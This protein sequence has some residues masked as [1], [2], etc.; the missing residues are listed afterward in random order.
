MVIAFPPCTHLAVSGAR[1]FAQKKRSGVQKKAIDF[2]M[3]FTELDVP[4]WAIENPVGIMSKLFRP[5]DQII[6]PFQFGDCAQKTTC[7]WLKNLPRLKPTKLVDKGEMRVWKSRKGKV[8]K[9]ARWVMD[10]LKMDP[11]LRARTR[12]QTFPGVAAAMAEQWGTNRCLEPP[13]FSTN[14]DAS[15]PRPDI[16]HSGAT[17]ASI[18][19]EKCC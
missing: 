12:S 11:A 6:Q 10:T 7:L 13:H 15:A 3:L 17:L 18:L 8:K 4:R 19:R 5:P 1:H 9:Q 14:L 16:V 2:F